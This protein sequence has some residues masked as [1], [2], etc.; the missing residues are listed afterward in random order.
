MYLLCGTYHLVFSATSIRHDI[1]WKG[2][3]NT[4]AF[5]G[6]METIASGCV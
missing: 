3:P 2:I 6:I 5:L 1:A 4:L